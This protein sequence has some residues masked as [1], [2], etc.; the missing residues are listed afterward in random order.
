[1]RSSASSE[2]TLTPDDGEQKRNELQPDSLLDK[3]VSGRSMGFSPA[4]ADAFRETSKLAEEF[5]M[6]PRAKSFKEEEEESIDDEHSKSTHSNN[7]K[8]SHLM[9]PP[10][11]TVIAPTPVGKST[12]PNKE[13]VVAESAD[14]EEE[15]QLKPPQNVDEKLID[16]DDSSDDGSSTSTEEESAE[17]SYKNASMR[18][19]SASVGS[20]GRS[21]GPPPPVPPADVT[22]PPAEPERMVTESTLDDDPEVAVTTVSRGPTIIKTVPESESEDSTST[23]TSATTTPRKLQTPKY[24]NSSDEENDND[25]K[26]EAP[27][28]EPIYTSIDTAVSDTSTPRAKEDKGDNK[29]ESSGYGFIE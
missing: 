5:R 18:P 19:R 13:G 20:R 14:S 24:S 28:D 2:R 17:H 7:S 16:K 12:S 1:M 25:G 8:R 15:Q 23:S 3:P 27:K 9:I 6:R 10:T 29:S 11:P 4:T 26:L 21:M 22:E